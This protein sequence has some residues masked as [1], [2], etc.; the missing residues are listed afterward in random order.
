MLVRCATFDGKIPITEE[1]FRQMPLRLRNSIFEKI[2]SPFG[3]DLYVDV[4]CP[5]CGEEF[6]A[7]LNPTENFI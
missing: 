6:K 7:Q 3:L 5:N 2:K 4:T 1:L